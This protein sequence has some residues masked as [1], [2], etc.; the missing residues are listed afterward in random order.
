[1]GW[2]RAEGP[3]AGGRRHHTTS[4]WDALGMSRYNSF[5]ILVG[6][7]GEGYPRSG[8][9]VIA[10]DPVIGRPKPNHKGHEGTQRK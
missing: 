2:D 9:L 8:D 3:I 5:G 1:M 4:K 6:G 7:Q 10:R